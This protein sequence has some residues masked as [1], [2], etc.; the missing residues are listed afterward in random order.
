M[1]DL[2]FWPTPNGKKI[3]ILLEEAGI[4]YNIKAIN[5]GRG[6]QLTPDFLQNLTQWP[7]A[8]DCRSRTDGRWRADHHLRVRRHHGIPGREEREVL[9]A[10]TASESRGPAVDVLADGQPGTQDGRAGALSARLRRIGKN[11]DQAYALL[12]FDNEVHRIYGVMNLGLHKKQLS[13]RGRVHDR[14]H[15]LLS[16]GDNLAGSQY[17]PRRIS[18]RQALAR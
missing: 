15:D 10:G 16:V 14:R 3:T 2:Y 17:R 6:D 4:P 18:Q 7:D 1:I 11:G 13:G 8:G 9:A 5:I 12:R